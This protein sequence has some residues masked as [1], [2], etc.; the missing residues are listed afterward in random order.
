MRVL[1]CSLSLI[2]GLVFPVFVAPQHSAAQAAGKVFTVALSQDPDTLDISLARSPSATWPTLQNI[3]E[4]LVGITPDGD[5]T[6]SL[7][8]WTISPDGLT[9]EFKLRK[10]VKFH[11]GDPLTARDI[12]FSQARLMEKSAF[13]KRR[14]TSFDKVEVVDEDTIRFLFKKPDPS[15]LRNR[16]VYVLSKTYY[17]RV[18][19]AEFVK[20]P[21]G[22]GPYQFV[23]FKPAQYF[24]VAAFDGYWGGA[25]QIKQ[26]RFLFTKADTTRVAQLRA[27]EVDLIMNTPFSDVA[28]LKQGGFKTVEVPIN[29]TVSVY[30]ETYNKKAPWADPR[31]RRAIAYAIDA[32]AIVKGL[33]M[34]VPKRFPGVA[35]DELGYDPALKFYPYDPAQAKKLLAEAGYPNG[36]HMPLVFMT[37]SYTGLKE[38]TEAVTLYLKAIGIDAEVRSYDG[39]QANELV[40]KSHG[41]ANAELVLVFP[42]IIANYTEVT[43]GISLE[44][45]SKSP[46][47]IYENPEVDRLYEEAA[48]AMDNQKRGEIIKQTMR[49]LH[50]DVAYIPLWNNVAV[51]SMKPKVSFTPIHRSLPLMY[52]KDVS[53]QNE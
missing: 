37:D 20:H 41:D 34:G 28:A 6:P 4:P 42:L 23:E 45:Y 44:F 24:D 46:Y 53:V 30:F 48:V 10:G 40:R 2:A 38:T 14:M 27:G 39:P 25:P 32:E 47:E 16:A 52:L 21:V 15:F 7:A 33:L 12:E 26:A 9:V 51:Y 11:S 8:T 50:D 17:D 18:G 49:V 36:F 29:P 19:E 43:D 31:V 13:Y 35:P 3:V 5:I 22:T 1:L